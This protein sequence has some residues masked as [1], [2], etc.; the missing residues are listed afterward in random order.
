MSKTFWSEPFL[1]IHL[2]G[3][4]L[5][6]LCLEVVWLGL[7]VDAPQL[8]FWLELILLGAFGVLPI[9]WMQWYRPFDIFSLLILV[10]KPQQLT[11]SQRK[12]LSLFKTRKHRFFSLIASGIMLGVLWKIYCLTPL[13]AT[14]ALV[15]PQ[16]RILGLTL[17][18]MAFLASNLFLQIPVSV[19]SVLMTSQSKFEATEAIAQEAIAQEF[20]LAGFRVRKILPFLSQVEV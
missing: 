20:T 8:P 13:A 7:A 18:G 10:V 3:L 17:A 15:L 1:W 5:L 6:P 14:V 9:L 4:A 19:L 2:A 16:S 12:I 11:E